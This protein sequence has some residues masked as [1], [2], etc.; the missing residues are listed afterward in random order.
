MWTDNSY[1][2]YRPSLRRP[3]DAPPQYGYD[4]GEPQSFLGGEMEVPQ[5]QS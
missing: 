2:S 3:G 1:G 4:G 5:V